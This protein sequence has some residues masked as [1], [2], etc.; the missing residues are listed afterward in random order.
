MDQVHKASDSEVLGFDCLSRQHRDESTTVVLR[1]LFP[2]A[3]V[4]TQ[5]MGHC[6]TSW[7]VAGSIHDEVIDFF[8]TL[9]NPARRTM[10]LGFTQPPRVMS[11]GKSFVG[12]KARPVRKAHNLNSI[13]DPIV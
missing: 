5:L 8:F 6:G 2:C 10:T 4:V 3:T 13:C 11:T 12:T 1:V 9:P 7:K